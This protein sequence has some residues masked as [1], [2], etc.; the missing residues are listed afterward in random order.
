MLTRWCSRDKELPGYLHDIDIIPKVL[1]GLDHV[2]PTITCP[3][4]LKL[5]A[6]LKHKMRSSGSWIVPDLK[7]FIF[8][9]LFYKVAGGIIKP[10]ADKLSL[11]GN[12][13]LGSQLHSKQRLT[14]A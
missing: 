11:G 14:K 2:S 8:R 1:L 10:I 3:L 9:F 13:T 12:G 6:L 4:P 7:L 5:C